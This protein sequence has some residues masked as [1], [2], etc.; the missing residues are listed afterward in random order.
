VGVGI[1]RENLPPTL[2][3]TSRHPTTLAYVRW[4]L[5]NGPKSVSYIQVLPK[6]YSKSSVCPVVHV[7]LLV[8]F[9]EHTSD[10]PLSYVCITDSSVCL[11]PE[12]QCLASNF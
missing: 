6:G 3:Q 4:F 10:G 8:R 11:L 2:C 1:Y 12:D 5:H 7:C 9:A